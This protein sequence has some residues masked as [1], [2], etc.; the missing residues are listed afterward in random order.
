MAGRK[1]RLLFLS[2]YFPPARTIASVRSGAIAKWIARRGWDVTVVT[3]RV[4]VW[5]RTEDPEGEERALAAEGIR[6]L[7]TPHPLSF[8]ASGHTVHF[9]ERLGKPGRALGARA[10]DRLRV[11]AS[12]WHLPPEIGWVRHVARLRLP[13]TE[14]P[15][16]V[17]ATGSPFAAF[18]SARRLADRYRCPF[19]LDYR[20]LWTGNPHLETPPRAAEVAR[21]A[22][23]L[24]ACAAATTV[25]PSLSRSLAESFGFATKIHTV[26]NGYD[27]EALQSI[28]P[29]DFGHFAVVYTGLFYPPKRVLTPVAAALAELQRRAPAD[30][31]DWRF[32][33]F[34]RHEEHVR[35]EAARHGISGR[36]ICHGEVS[37]REAL[38]AVRGAGVSVVISTVMNQGTLADEGVVTGK[39]F[40]AI[41]LR[42]P[43]LAIAPPTSDLAA[44]IET[45][46]LS[47]R[48]VGE[49]ISGI[50][51]FLHDRMRGVPMPGGRPE[52]YDWAELGPQL[53][54]ILRETLSASERPAPRP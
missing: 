50:A 28:R 52:A 40:E 14:A 48:F 21:E 17:L 42:T 7:R 43:I 22:S 10:A 19:A 37:R 23:L 16:L 31:P 1:P 4:D 33:Y 32:H 15:D 6:C 8:L 24:E 29:R 39:V 34:G 5:K 41:G 20:D 12:L 54:R 27:G 53:D 13:N 35:D 3:P 26:S 46:G 45:S 9:Y 38:E 18:D 2:Y 11:L 44:V 25:S 36:V 51:S 49:D 30:L 47:R